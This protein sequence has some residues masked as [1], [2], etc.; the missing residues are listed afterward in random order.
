[1]PEL[2]AA[3]AVLQEDPE[4]VADPPSSPVPPKEAPPELVPA[5]DSVSVQD[6]EHAT[7]APAPN[8]AD[9]DEGFPP[10][11]SDDSSTAASHGDVEMGVHQEPAPRQHQATASPATN[12]AD[13]DN[14]FPLGDADDSSSAASHASNEADPDVG[15]QSNDEGDSSIAALGGGDESG[16]DQQQVP[17]PAGQQGTQ[18]D[19]AVP[20]ATPAGAGPSVSRAHNRLDEDRAAHVQDVAPGPCNEKVPCAHYISHQGE[21]ARDGSEKASSDE[22]ILGNVE[23]KQFVVELLKTNEAKDFLK[24]RANDKRDKSCM[25]IAAHRIEL[26]FGR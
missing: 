14:D 5:E 21:A 19:V 12:E 10:N 18:F 2:A 8:E 4:D 15:F 23:I 25:E 13:R 22:P 3:L 7:A 9:L 26:K 1:V 20:S 6:G 24:K 16:D 11:N 17:P